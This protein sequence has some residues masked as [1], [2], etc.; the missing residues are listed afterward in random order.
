MGFSA[1]T[2]GKLSAKR[3]VDITSNTIASR[4]LIYAGGA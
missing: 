3:G 1:G 4:V 2:G